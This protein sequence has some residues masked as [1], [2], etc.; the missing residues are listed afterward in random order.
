MEATVGLW[1]LRVF[2]SIVWVSFWPSEHPGYSSADDSLLSE[3]PEEKGFKGHK[4]CCC[5]EGLCSLLFNTFLLPVQICSCTE[6]LC[7]GLKPA[8]LWL[9][10]GYQLCAPAARLASRLHSPASLVWATSLSTSLR[11]D[12]QAQTELL[13][14]IKTITKHTCKRTGICMDDFFK[15]QVSHVLQMFGDPESFFIFRGNSSAVTVPPVNLTL[16]NQSDAALGPIM[17][18]KYLIAKST[19]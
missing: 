14:L 9:M 19:F 8:T 7:P 10:L 2:Y 11:F 1:S 16:N 18:T 12:F 13:L 4:K 15:K 3:I 5:T 17:W 6:I